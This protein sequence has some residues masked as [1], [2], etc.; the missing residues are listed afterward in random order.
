MDSVQ[1]SA[2]S[3]DLPAFGY[4]VAHNQE[5]DIFYVKVFKYKTLLH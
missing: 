4:W 1:L 2:N 3:K 5:W